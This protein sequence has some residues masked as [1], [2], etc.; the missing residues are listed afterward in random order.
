MRR[1][2]IKLLIRWYVGENRKITKLKSEEEFV[3]ALF[4]TPDATRNIMQSMMTGYTRWY[5]EAKSDEERWIIKG[6][7]LAMKALL[8]AHT[9]ATNINNKYNDEQIEQKIKDW[10]QAMKTKQ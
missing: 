6:G 1:F 4:D 3:Y 8:Q 10:K 7:T 9:T 2:L 5:F